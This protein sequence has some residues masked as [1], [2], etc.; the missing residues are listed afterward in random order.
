MIFEQ[1]QHGS[2]ASA[3]E[4]LRCRC[5]SRRVISVRLWLTMCFTSR[6]A[7]RTS[8]DMPDSLVTKRK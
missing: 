1:I 5:A 6:S 7:S 4:V 8:G 2:T 3:V